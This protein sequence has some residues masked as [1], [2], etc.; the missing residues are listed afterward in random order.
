MFPML[1]EPVCRTKSR[2]LC[3]TVPAL[4]TAALADVARRVSISVIAL[5]GNGTASTPACI[6]AGPIGF[7]VIGEPMRA[8]DPAALARALRAAVAPSAD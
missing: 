4:G 6:A 8:A 5:G 2:A 7:V 1:S 3:N